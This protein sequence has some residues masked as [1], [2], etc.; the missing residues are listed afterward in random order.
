MFKRII[1]SFLALIFALLPFG[2]VPEQKT[3]AEFNGT[4]IQSW[5]CLWWDD[6]RWQEEIEYMKQ[7]GIEYL[8]LQ[9][10]ASFFDA[11][12]AEL[13]YPSELECFE[14]CEK[15]GDV[16]GDVLR[17]CT[18]SGIKVFVGFADYEA[19]W[20]LAGLSPQYNKICDKMA[21]MAEEIYNKYYEE[22]S[23]AFYGWYFTPE[24]NNV[25]TMK[26]SIFNIAKGFN[27]IIDT[28]NELNPDMPMLLSPYFTNY[29][30]VPSVIG[31][32]PEWQAFLQAAHLR[33]G[34]IIAPQDA[35]GAGWIKMNDLEKVWKMYSAAVKSCDK[36]IKLW[37]NCENMT[38]ARGFVPLM[39]PATVENENMTATLDRFAEQMNIASKYV[40]NIITFSFNHYYCPSNV[41]SVYFD[42]YLDYMKNGDKLETEA[43]TAPQNVTVS[44]GV[45][46]WDEAEDNIGIA[47]YLIYKGKKA[48]ARIESGSELSYELDGKKN[49][50]IAAFD[51]AGNK[52]E[53]VECR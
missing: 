30:S 38:V 40:D 29:I 2:K 48:V 8:I 51:G 37:A 5:Y 39:P 13:H 24:I 25:P 42:T 27:K 16:I 19:W 20:T 18:D 22:Y 53:V 50:S 44:D 7:A 52:S 1:S 31:A 35:V 21:L 41:N 4:F 6:A 33:D 11:D 3:K 43:P 15:Y 36:D 49:Y 10:T 28:V 26:L 46:T 45:L 14:S 9:D 47:Y 32:L 12:S 23:D 17:N 34:D